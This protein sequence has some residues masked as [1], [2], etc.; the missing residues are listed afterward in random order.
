MKNSDIENLVSENIIIGRNPIIE[1]LKNG[2]EMTKI[3]LAKDAEGSVRKITGIA[4]DRGIPV[5]YADRGALDRAA[6]G[7]NHQGAVAYVSEFEYC[8]VEDILIKAEEKG[9]PAF[10]IVLDGIED[11]HN[12]GAIMRSADGAG[13]HGVIIPKRRAAAVTAVA[14]KASA[15]AAEYVAVAR[16]TNIGQ[17]IDMLKE[18]GVWTAAV[19]MDGDAFYSSDLKGPIAIVIGSEGRGIGRLVKEKCD[20]CVSIPMKGGVNSL[21]A[22][23]AAAVLMYEVVR[24]RAVN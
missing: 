1:A 7:G 13:A 15:G 20:F 17:T 19:D 16:V 9:E 10:I 14:E 18:N 12:L 23:N 21:N 5:Q 6:G 4:K 2:R 11:P 8:E 3:L 22:S 24:Q